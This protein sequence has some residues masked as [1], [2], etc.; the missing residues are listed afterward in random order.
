M[1]GWSEV[2]S[3]QAPGERSGGLATCSALEMT[4][5]VSSCVLGT[6]LAAFPDK[7]FY[8][9]SLRGK[10][11]LTHVSEVMALE[12]PLLPCDVR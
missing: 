1:I 8:F 10:L 12:V 11:K 7:G 3:G 2:Q 6:V 9:Y 4:E 5:L